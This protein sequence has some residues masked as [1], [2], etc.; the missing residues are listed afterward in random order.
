MERVLGLAP[1]GVIYANSSS[2]SDEELGTV[3]AAAHALNLTVKLRP[4]IDPRYESVPGCSEQTAGSG[5]CT[6]PG[7]GFIGEQFT[8]QEW[9]EFFEGVDGYG[10]YILH[11][12]ELAQRTKCEILSVGVETGTIMKQEM[13]MRGLIER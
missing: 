5:G 7:R 8:S 2:P 10:A 6:N 12:A 11:M 4:T 9:Q 1:S 3:I 13:H